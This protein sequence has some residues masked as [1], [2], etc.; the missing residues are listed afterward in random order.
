MNDPYPVNWHRDKTL[1][2]PG[3]LTTSLKVKHAMLHDAGSWHY[4][5]HEIVKEIQ[6]KLMEVANLDRKR[7]GFEIVLLQGSG[8]YGV[9]SVLASAIPEFGKLLI[10]SNGAYGERMMA[11]AKA[12]KID[13]LVYRTGED[14]PPDPEQI[15]KLLEA[16]KD[17]THVAVVHCETTTG[18]I[19]PI[20][21]IG[22]IVRK[23]QRQYIVDAMSSFGA[24]EI[25]F[26]KCFIDY[27]ISSPNKCFEG[28][29]GFAFVFLKRECLEANRGQQR[30]LSLDLLHQLEY[31]EAKGQFRYTP[32]THCILA[33]QQALVEFEQEG[34]VAGREARYRRN[35][36]VL[37]EGMKDLGF[38]P[39]LKPE[40]QGY[41]ITT[42]HFPKHPNFEFS[43]FYKLLSDQGMLIYPGKLT[44]T[45]CFRIGNVGRIFE[46]DMRQL[47]QSIE[48][49]LKEM[50]ITL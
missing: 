33:F 15:D 47:L 37:I 27:L 4:E 39:F 2:T 14:E 26:H 43:Q 25:D 11:M 45:E 12:L 21:A 35:H 9:E 1:F 23:N 19:N 34:G 44:D 50:E 18:I 30:S 29:P 41:M 5:F 7:D 31:F 17:I 10:H 20:E 28:V 22:K 42:F 38:V 16:D 13:H 48:Y 24:I 6:D 32:P 36:K 3:P 49:A 46:H 8:T 40:L